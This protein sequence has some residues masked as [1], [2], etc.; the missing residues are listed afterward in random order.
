MTRLDQ[1]IS[2]ELRRDESSRVESERDVSVL[3]AFETVGSF[4]QLE[5]QV[6]SLD[7]SN[8]NNLGHWPQVGEFA[9]AFSADSWLKIAG[10]FII[11]RCKI[12]QLAFVVTSAQAA[13]QTS[14]PKLLRLLRLLYTAAVSP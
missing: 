6:V 2:I 3:L 7:S 11:G 10:Q 13:E 14:L 4:G 1:L 9:L 12:V 5:S 8:S